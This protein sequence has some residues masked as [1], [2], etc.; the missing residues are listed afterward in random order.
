LEPSMDVLD[1]KIEETSQIS[2]NHDEIG[3]L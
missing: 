3:L 1:I 2:S